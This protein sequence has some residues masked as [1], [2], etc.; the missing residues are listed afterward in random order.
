V[1]HDVDNW[2]K[3]LGLSKYSGL[4]TENEIDFDVLAELNEQ[5]LKDLQIPL[6]PRKKILKGIEVLR[7]GA[8]A[9]EDRFEPANAA[10]PISR[11][12]AE[13]RQLTVMFCD[14]VDSTSLSTRFD[15]EDLREIIQA[16]Q[17]ACAHVIA[18]YGGYIAKFMGDGILVYFGYPQAHEDD[19]KRA[20][21]AALKIVEVVPNVGANNS[22]VHD[23]L[24]VRIGI[25]TGP[26][27]V[28][29]IVGEGAAEEASVIG[30]TPNIAARLQ[31]IAQS[32]QIVISP[33][34]RHIIG[35]VFELEDLGH[36]TLKGITE[37]V[38]AWRVLGARGE[39]I[40]DVDRAE[41]SSPLV[42]R[43]E[44]LGLLLR[45]WGAS[46]SGHG[47]VVL[48]QGEA[49]FGKSRLVT[50]LRTK[51][52]ERSDNPAAMIIQCSS[53]HTSSTFY[54]VI[55]HLKRVLNW[56]DQDAQDELCPAKIDPSGV[57]PSGV[58]SY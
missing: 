16:Y 20:I 40:S 22:I 3:G 39:G 29:D 47:Q 28:G 13:R 23:R 9:I 38:H 19:G 11:S 32:N 31:T 49:G 52:S 41:P 37:P 7:D 35:D 10:M 58:I 2:L 14:L 26:V 27:V 54:P 15:P 43:Q 5:D 50:A 18:E 48:I 57:P 25:S 1:A 17:E 6:G 30:E 56:K 12:E 8:G 53:F 46:K 4:F 42:G 55:Q 21:R 51:I 34:T 36:K 45:T 44:E 33:L 24:S